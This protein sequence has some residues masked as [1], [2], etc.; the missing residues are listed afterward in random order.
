LNAD[1]KFAEIR[2]LRAH[3]IKTH[4]VRFF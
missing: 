3:G 2:V 4:F 1:K